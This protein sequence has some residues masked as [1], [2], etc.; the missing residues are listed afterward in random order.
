MS[1][2]VRTREQSTQDADTSAGIKRHSEYI[3]DW[4]QQ[5]KKSKIALHQSFKLGQPQS[6]IQSA[7]AVQRGRYSIRCRKDIGRN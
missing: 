6:A 4:K 1:R 5:V 3:E 7:P 2:N